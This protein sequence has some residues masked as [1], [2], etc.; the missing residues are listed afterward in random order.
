MGNFT[1]ENEY[2]TNAPLDST[3][4]SILNVYSAT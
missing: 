3:A 4:F 2:L 1:G